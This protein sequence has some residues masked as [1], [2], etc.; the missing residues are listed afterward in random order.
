MCFRV[1]VD[2]CINDDSNSITESK[3]RYVWSNGDYDSMRTYLYGFKWTDLLVSNFTPDTIWKAFCDVID[4]AINMFVPSVA[5]DGKSNSNLLKVRTYPR[6]IRK[7]F[8]EKRVL[9]RA[10]K[11]YP[12]SST[13]RSNYNRVRAECRL[14]VKRHEEYLENK[15]ISASNPSAFYK[16]VR[17]RMANKSGIGVLSEPGGKPATDDKRKADLLNNYFASACVPDDG[18]LPLFE[19][20][21][22]DSVNEFIESIDF[23][24]N[25]LITSIR[26]TKNKSK[27]SCGPD[28][29]PALILTELCPVIV[30]PLSLIFNSFMSIGKLPSDWKKAV[31]TPIFKKGSMS[32]CANYRPISQTSIFCK[33]MERV[34][35]GDLTDYLLE[36]I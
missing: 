16:H 15:V 7:L 10:H 9:W 19:S 26:R 28:N 2:S 35:V 6:H 30:T 31:V 24:D 27:F 8:S 23:T 29:Y 32:D 21:L 14:A 13:V 11:R 17:R 36:K 4:S 22:T 12:S 3:I 1:S 18:T 25:K 5:A 34:I 33:L 20:R